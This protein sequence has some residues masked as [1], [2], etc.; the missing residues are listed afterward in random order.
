MALRQGPG[1]TQGKF[2]KA[3]I[4]RSALARKAQTKGGSHP[5]QF[6]VQEGYDLFCDELH[7][8]GKGSWAEA[9]RNAYAID[10]ENPGNLTTRRADFARDHERC[11]DTIENWENRGMNDLMASLDV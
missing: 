8:L 2:K 3:E 1:L 6:S 4:L 9:I 7:S 10:L 11:P 5:R